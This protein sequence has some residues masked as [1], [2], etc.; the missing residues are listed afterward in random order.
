[1]CW[2]PLYTNKHKCPPVVVVIGTELQVDVNLTIV[3]SLPQWRPVVV[4][5]TQ[6]H[7]TIIWSGPHR[8]YNT[9]QHFIVMLNLKIVLKKSNINP[10]KVQHNVFYSTR[11]YALILKQFKKNEIKMNSFKI[12]KKNLYKILQGTTEDLLNLYQLTWVK[13]CIYKINI[14]TTIN[15]HW[16]LHVFLMT[17]NTFCFYCQCPSLI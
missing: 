3:W 2:T 16:K 1:M 8:P 17:E 4:I 11:L 15:S 10:I 12:I 14:I 13:I 7:T 6:L 9:Y 5:G